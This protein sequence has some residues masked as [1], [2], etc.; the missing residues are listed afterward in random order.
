[1]KPSKKPNTLRRFAALG[2]EAQV[3]NGVA[4]TFYAPAGCCGWV[5]AG[6]ARV[7]EGKVQTVRN[8]AV[9]REAAAALIRK[10]EAR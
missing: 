1:M 6:T 2:H 9:P 5:A 10:I 4:V 7:K 3:V 8:L